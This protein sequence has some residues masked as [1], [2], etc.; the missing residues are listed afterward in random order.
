MEKLDLKDKKIL[1]HLDIDSRQSFSQIG[2]KVGLHKDVVA[3]RVKK[4]LDNGIIKNFY[5]VIDTSPLG[6]THPRFYLT[7]QYATPEIKEEIIDYFVKSKYV[8]FVHENGGSHDLSLVMVVKNV[9]EFNY[10]WEK[11]MIK[12][13]DY[14]S[15]QKFSLYLR[16]S[17]YRYSFF[18]DESTTERSDRT[19]VEVFGGE[20]KVEIDDLDRN[21]LKLITPNARMQTM[22][23]A[24]KFNSTAVTINNR[25]K[26][27]MKGN[28]IKGFKVNVDFSKLGYHF[29]KVDI[30]LKEPEKHSKILKYIETNPYLN[31]TMKS[32]GYVDLEVMFYL[33]NA[34]QL[35]E[36][37]RDLS[38]K[39]PNSIK[40]YTYSL[41]IKTHK[42]NYMPEE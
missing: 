30:A 5:T 14:F 36:I 3:N 16:E 25:I 38:T 12:Y 23:I 9:P 26:K 37:M 6:Y 19:K 13:R 41:T 42:W 8:G 10:F 11:T 33:N 31:H 7:Y 29:Y 35:H 24:K 39:F 22:E 27:L 32:I 18:F 4:L 15:N 34:N 28:V 2:R 40:N 1:F 21:I 17:M 20:N